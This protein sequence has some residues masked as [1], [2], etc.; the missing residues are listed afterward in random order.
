[1]AETILIR[2]GIR[3]KVLQFGAAHLTDSEL[4]TLLLDVRFSPEMAAQ[5]L[6]THIDFDLHRLARLSVV[7]LR[8]YGGIGEIQALRLISAIELGRRRDHMPHPAQPN[9]RSSQD[10]YQMIRPQLMDLRHEEFWALLLN[11][12]H[13]LILKK[14]ISRGGVSGTV[15]DPKIIFKSAVDELAC[16]VIVA[17]NHPS[18]HLKPSQSDLSLTQKL[19]KAGKLLEIPLL[20]HLILNNESYLSFADE[21]LI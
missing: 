1:M 19:V 9:I 21:Q 5:T 3:Q 12:N 15:V 18:G 2:D 11:R 4:L 20:D 16:A 14:L 7:E 13:K 6:L 8:K 17:H 10:A